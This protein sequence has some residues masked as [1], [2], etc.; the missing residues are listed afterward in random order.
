M[1]LEYKKTFNFLG[2][3]RGKIWMGVL[4]V[5]GCGGCGGV[6]GV[7]GGMWGVWGGDVAYEKLSYE[8]IPLSYRLIC[9]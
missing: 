1:D 8:P 9:P 4:G 3:L 6:C 7:C 5:G 2:I